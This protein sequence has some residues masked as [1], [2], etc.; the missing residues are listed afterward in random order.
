MNIRLLARGVKA[1]EPLCLARGHRTR[2]VSLSPDQT[3]KDWH[4]RFITVSEVKDLSEGPALSL[5]EGF[6]A[7]FTRSVLQ[8]RYFAPTLG[9]SGG[10]GL[11]MTRSKSHRVRCPNVLW[12]DLGRLL[13]FS[14]SL[15]FCLSLTFGLPSA[16]LAGHGF[17]SAFGNIEWLP[18]PGRAPDS[19]MYRLDAV[20]E[21]SQ[22]LLARTATDKMRLY[23]TFTREKLAEVEAMVKAEN[24]AAAATA[25]ERYTA[26]LDR[27]EEVVKNDTGETE[28]LAEMLATA[29]LEHQYILSVIYAELPVSTRSVVRQTITTAHERYQAVAK[30]LPPKK[31][32][33]FFFK[34][35]EVRWSVDMA[36]RADEA[37]E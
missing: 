6:F 35:E 18:A 11:R 33:A 15:A 29:L 8:L 26:Y 34:E 28:A 32:G 20:R 21:E 16:T 9:M 36:T 37:G 14:R 30:L 23:L 27:A 22:L 19:T 25:A 13:S 1:A 3:T 12:S 17:A 7:K 31:K 10:E 2:D 5:V 4:P 24:S